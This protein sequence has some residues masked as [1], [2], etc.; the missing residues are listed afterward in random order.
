[1]EKLIL[2]FKETVLKEMPVDKD[3]ITIG[4]RPD[5]D[6]CIDNPVVSGAHARV[7]R[8]GPDIILEDLNSTN[9]TFVNQKKVTKHI[10]NHKDVVFIGK[11]TIVFL[12]EDPVKQAAPEPQQ[13]K[14]DMDR[15]MVLET[16]AHQTMAGATV[17]AAA[18]GNGMLTVLEGSLEKTEF[19][20][21][22]RLTTLGKADT[23]TIKMKGLLTP[24]TAALINKTNDGYYIQP[25]SSGATIKVN[26]NKI[27]E[28]VL[29]KDGDMIELYGLKLV[30]NL[31]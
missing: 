28:R 13:K 25:P 2:N 10:L 30:F 5:N 31:S 21:K 8:Q 27:G 14:D 16:K 9:G 18:A 4:R 22:S 11:H 20:L 12:S 6:I 24:Q 19:E 26:G 23:S 29:L 17:K 1:M 3:V 7:V 15:T